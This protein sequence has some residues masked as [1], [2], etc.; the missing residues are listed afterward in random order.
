M[1]IIELF[2]CSLLYVFFNVVNVLYFNVFLAV[3]NGTK[4]KNWCN[5]SWK[6]NMNQPTLWAS[7]MCREEDEWGRIS[8][9]YLANWN[10]NSLSFFFMLIILYHECEVWLFP[11]MF[12]KISLICIIHKV[13]GL[14]TGHLSISLKLSWLNGK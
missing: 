1:S 12:G 13:K 3:V 7:M 4:A 8:N 14:T 5:I 10:K 6:F 2:L 9:I 11:F